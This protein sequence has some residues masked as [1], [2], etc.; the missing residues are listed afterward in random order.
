MTIR[1]VTF[2]QVQCDQSGCTETTETLGGD[3]SAWGNT[4]GAEDD[5]VNAEGQATEDGKHFCEQHRVPECC[6][7]GSTAVVVNDAPDGSGDWYCE[8]CRTGETD[9][10]AVMN[11]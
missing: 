8:K 6:D 7:C 10:T 5:W 11:A 2:Y 3:Y 9:Q 1:E 4:S